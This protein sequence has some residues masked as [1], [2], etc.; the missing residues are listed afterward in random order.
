MNKK[1]G[2]I[3]LISIL[4]SV[5]YESYWYFIFG[6]WVFSFWIFLIESVEV[7]LIISISYF[8]FKFIQKKIK[9]IRQK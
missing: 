4:I 9:I 2:A 8:T 3:I 6:H 7:F 5:A 1:F